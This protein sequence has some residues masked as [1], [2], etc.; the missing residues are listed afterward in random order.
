M[1]MR[2]PMQPVGTNIAASLPKISAA[3][4]SSRFTVGSSL[5]T[6]SPTSAAAIAWR[7]SDVGFVT[8]SLRKSTTFCPAVPVAFTWSGST[9]ASTYGSFVDLLH[10]FHKNFVRYAQFLRREPYDISTSLDQPRRC[11]ALESRSYRD[12]VFRFD[13]IQIDPVELPQAE[14]QLFFQ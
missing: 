1:A 3:R 5:Y 12:A 6:S 11:Q 10:Q 9:S 13:L 14:E 7:I 4:A 8:V 2:F